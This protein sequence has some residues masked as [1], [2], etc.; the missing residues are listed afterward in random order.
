MLRASSQ[1]TGTDVDMAAVT[2]DIHTDAGIEHGADLL[3]FTEAVMR[4]DAATAERQRLREILPPESFV[5]V[6]AV[7]GSF[8]VVD[9]IADA[10]GIPLDAIMLEMSKDVRAQL[11]LARFASAV[12]TLGSAPSS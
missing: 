9:R 8:N 7:I 12:N 3:A 5:D 2:G 10:T 6:A 1:M 4:G 11:D